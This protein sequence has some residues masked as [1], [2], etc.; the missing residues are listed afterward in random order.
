MMPMPLEVEVTLSNGKKEMYYMA[1]DLMRGEKQ[2][3][4]YNYDWKI[5]QDWKWVNTSYVLELP[6]SASD[7]QSVV[8][9][10]S[11][12]MADIDRSN[13]ELKLGDGIEFILKKD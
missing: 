9:D 8:I 6:Y 4:N 1:L 11:E 13:N 2:K 12:G 3:G 10:P 5:L 7:I